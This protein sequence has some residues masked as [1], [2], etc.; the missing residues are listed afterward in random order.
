MFPIKSF[1][2]PYRNRV[3]LSTKATAVM[4]DDLEH[5]RL[6]LQSL[7]CELPGSE[8]RRAKLSEEVEVC[9]KDLSW[10]A[11][12]RLQELKAWI[13]ARV[14]IIQ[15]GQDT[16]S[17]EYLE[18]DEEQG[19][20]VLL[21]VVACYGAKRQVT[22]S[23]R[24]SHKKRAEHP[25]LGALRG[26]LR[27]HCYY[28][29]TIQWI[30]DAEDEELRYQ[31]STKGWDFRLPKLQ[32]LK[33]ALMR[34]V[35]EIQDFRIELQPRRMVVDVLERTGMV[36]KRLEELEEG[37]LSWAMLILDLAR[38]MIQA[39][40]DSDPYSPDHGTA[41]RAVVLIDC[42]EEGL[43]EPWAAARA[44]PG[45][46][47]AFPNTQF[48]ITSKNK[49]ILDQAGAVLWY[50]VRTEPQSFE[51]DLSQIE[52]NPGEPYPIGYTTRYLMHNIRVHPC[53]IES[54]WE[55]DALDQDLVWPEDMEPEDGHRDRWEELLL[56]SADLTT[57]Y[58]GREGQ[59]S[60][61]KTFKHCAYLGMF[62]SD[63]Q[64]HDGRPGHYDAREH[65]VGN[66][67]V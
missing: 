42:V 40:Y 20:P 41:S 27:A 64:D 37:A 35:R 14:K 15:D 39:N 47:D 38:R 4:P 55:G 16:E 60:P 53:S 59:D 57:E 49:D 3:E 2:L 18:G 13:R 5:L 30:Y 66:H 62:E 24:F 51:T 33:R 10:T 31:V 28:A 44:L 48:V 7:V 19:V 17:G 46:Q 34:A 32:A 52:G 22:E 43:D 11:G 29:D 23:L 36:T 12:G 61:D 67:F 25:R 58:F 26:A 54:C 9:G 65:S 45:L 6:A 63:E 50:Q 8:C 1:A 56:Y 21:P